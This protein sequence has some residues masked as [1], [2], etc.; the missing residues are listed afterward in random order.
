[1][2]ESEKIKLGGFHFSTYPTTHAIFFLDSS[3]M[4]IGLR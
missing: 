3:E 4:N 2:P 1:M